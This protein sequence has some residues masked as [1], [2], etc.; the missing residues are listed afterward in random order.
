MK[1]KFRMR[2][3]YRN[4]LSFLNWSEIFFFNLFFVLQSALLVT[5]PQTSYHGIKK[6]LELSSSSYMVAGKF[7]CSQSQTYGMYWDFLFPLPCSVWSP[8]FPRLSLHSHFLIPSTRGLKYSPVPPHGRLF[9]SLCF[10]CLFP[11]AISAAGDCILSL[12][13]SLCLWL[14]L[15]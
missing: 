2:G 4:T 7:T 9:M 12:V 11:G 10:C 14:L 1:N 5:E 8:G 3:S 15:Q 6:D 13:L